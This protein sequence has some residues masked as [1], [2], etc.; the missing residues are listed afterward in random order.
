V[1]DVA[2]T[3]DEAVLIAALTLAMV[4]TALDDTRPPLAMPHHLLKAASWRAARDGLGGSCVNPVTGHTLPTPVLV[5]QLIGRVRPALQQAGDL[6]LVLDLLESLVAK[7]CGAT[8]QRR[9][10]A[11]N[12]KFTDVVDLL[13]A[14]TAGADDLV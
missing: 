6:D 1:C 12:G 7:G 13:T 4:A 11:R 3:A 9:A 8:R 2:A 5:R 10:F 14:Q